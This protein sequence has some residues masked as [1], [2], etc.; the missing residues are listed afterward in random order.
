M[1]FNRCGETAK[2]MRVMGHGVSC[3]TIKNPL[4]IFFWVGIILSFPTSMSEHD[5][6]INDLRFCFFLSSSVTKTGG[7]R[8]AHSGCSL[9]IF[10]VWNLPTI[11]DNPQFWS[12][13]PWCVSLF[14]NEYSGGGFCLPCL[15]V[16]VVVRW[17]LSN[18]IP[19]LVS[20]V[21]FLR[22]SRFQPPLMMCSLRY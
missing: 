13:S 8:D 14:R 10:L 2:I 22:L 4:I 1:G 5:F 9:A 11:R 3:P 20:V 18:S 15:V 19:V 21:C 6:S 7:L 16:M 17:F 12:K